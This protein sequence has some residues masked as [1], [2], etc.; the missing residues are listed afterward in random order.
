MNSN[1]ARTFPALVAWKLTN[2]WLLD[3]IKD[4]EN[5]DDKARCTNV[6]R[7]FGIGG[8]INHIISTGR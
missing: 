1:I 6:F 3:G 2:L 8:S 7:I 5:K 4:T